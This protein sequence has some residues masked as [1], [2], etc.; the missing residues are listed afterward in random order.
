MFVK[1]FAHML[2]PREVYLFYYGLKGPIFAA[3]K[4]SVLRDVLEEATDIYLMGLKSSP[5]SPFFCGQY[6]SV[7]EEI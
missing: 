6:Q 1:Q 7:F 3:K 5:K 2:Y 4:V